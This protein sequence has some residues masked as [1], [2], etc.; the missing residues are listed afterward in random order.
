MADFVYKVYKTGGG[1]LL[2]SGWIFFIFEM[3]LV[4]VLLESEK[5]EGVCERDLFVCSSFSRDELV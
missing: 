1:S 4:T 5:F 2:V 3:I